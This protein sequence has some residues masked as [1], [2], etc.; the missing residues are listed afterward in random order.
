MAVTVRD[1]DNGLKAF[2]AKLKQNYVC[3][4]GI[5]E[6][7]GAESKEVAEGQEP[8][9]QTLIDVA[10]QHEF[11]LGVPQRSFVR[12]YA[13]ANQDELEAKLSAA[14]KT[15][16]QPGGRGADQ[17]MARFGLYVV[18]QMQQNIADGIAPELSPA[19]LAYKK[20]LNINENAKETP[21][22]LTGQLRSS[23]RSKVEKA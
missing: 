17:Q 10:E 4:V 8:S 13:D 14:M 11:G 15:A 21:L 6:A 23:I 20:S 7:E 5:H 16:L 12:G 9:G 19:T 3:T 22:I 18:G 1:R 2:T